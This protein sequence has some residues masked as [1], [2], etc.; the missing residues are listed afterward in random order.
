V[1]ETRRTAVDPTNG[2][3]EDDQIRHVL[4]HVTGDGVS[5]GSPVT[6]VPERFS[7]FVSTVESCIERKASTLDHHRSAAFD[8][9]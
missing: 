4:A 5:L 9:G 8:E 3:W 7:E 2:V 6:N 1:D